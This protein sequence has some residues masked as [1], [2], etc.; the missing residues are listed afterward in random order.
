LREWCAII[1]AVD[2]FIG[3]DSCGQHIR[4]CF[5]K[6]ASVVV[7]GTHPINITYDN[8]HIIERDEKFYPDSMRIS[9]LQSHLSSRLN[10]PRIEFTQDEIQK[11]YEE[12]KFNIEGEDKKEEFVEKKNKSRLGMRYK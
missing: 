1:D 10:E 12:I 6:K 5:D 2:Y 9:G 3:C 4:K 7:A 11:A 8:F